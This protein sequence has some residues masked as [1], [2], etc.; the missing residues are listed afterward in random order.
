MFTIRDVIWLA[1]VFLLGV[2]G[3]VGV[4]VQSRR[5]GQLQERIARLE[6][7]IQRGGYTV[8]D[9]VDGPVLLGP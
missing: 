7:A 9:D 3:S 8:D 5:V 1:V 2:S 6:A 4:A